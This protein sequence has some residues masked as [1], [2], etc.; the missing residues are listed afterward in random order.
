MIG[1]TLLPLVTIQ[2]G[3]WKLIVKNVVPV[4]PW[5]SLRL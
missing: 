4:L 5:Y 1:L 3:N 2:V